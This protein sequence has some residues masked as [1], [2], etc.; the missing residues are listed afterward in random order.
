ML[1]WRKGA[2]SLAKSKHT[3]EQIID[4]LRQAEVT[5]AQWPLAPETV[6]PWPSYAALYPKVVVVR[7]IT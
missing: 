5:A 2:F 3:A 6:L 1:D 4:K 7:V